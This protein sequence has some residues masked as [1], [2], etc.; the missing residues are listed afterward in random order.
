MLLWQ[1][2]FWICVLMVMHTYLIYPWIL[3]MVKASLST[4]AP[5]DYF[6][7]IDILIAAYNEEEVIEEKIR[8]ILSGDY[9]LD[10]IRVLVGSDGSTD[11]TEEILTSLSA[12]YSCIVLHRFKRGGK[13]KVVNSLMEKSKSELVIFTDANVLFSQNLIQEILRPFLAPSVALVGADIRGCKVSNEGIEFQ[14]NEYLQRETRMKWAEGE[15]WGTMMGAFGGC[16]AM[17]SSSFEPIPI[18][19]LVD[20]FY[21]SMKVLEQGHSSILA[22]EA[23]CYEDISSKMSEEFR[24]KV[25]MSR[26]NFQ[27]LRKFSHF[28]LHHRK[29]LSFSF[30]SHKVLRWISPMA[31]ITAL[32]SSLMLSGNSNFYL[33][34]FWLQFVIMFSPLMLMTLNAIGIRSRLVTFV[35]YFISMNVALFLGMLKSFRKVEKAIWEPTLRNQ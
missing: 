30:I 22:K 4:E 9:P 2:M 29:G 6:P 26:G 35:A 20:D 14:E 18:E 28:L 8:S 34:L 25:R 27:N 31:L 24:R 1:F 12:E 3:S 5:L 16:Y 19:F 17:R 10:K 13:S 23:I 21:L 11:R 7:S 33:V 15:K 32:L